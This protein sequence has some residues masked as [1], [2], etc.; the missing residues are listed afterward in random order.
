M[1]P[2]GTVLPEPLDADEDSLRK[3]FVKKD[4]DLGDVETSGSW[5]FSSS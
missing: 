3:A 2:L 4:G 1:T 5:F